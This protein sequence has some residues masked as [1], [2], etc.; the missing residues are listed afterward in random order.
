[1]MSLIH[2]LVDFV[3]AESG[4]PVKHGLEYYNANPMMFRVEDGT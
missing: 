4:L 3:T 1:M 2:F